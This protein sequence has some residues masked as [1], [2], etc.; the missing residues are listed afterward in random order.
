MKRKIKY[1]Q[2][3]LPPLA[4]LVRAQSLYL[5]GP[6]FESKR[7]DNI[8]SKSDNKETYVLLQK[9]NGV[10][11]MS[12]ESN[13]F[14]FLREGD[15][16]TDTEIAPFKSQENS[17]FDFENIVL[18]GVG[19]ELPLEGESIHDLAKKLVIKSLGIEGNNL[20][21]SLSE[22][23][24][25]LVYFYAKKLAEMN[26]I[27]DMDLPLDQDVLVEHFDV[28]GTITKEELVD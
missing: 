16:D 12:R 26:N 22:K 21:L 3:V 7:V 27:I 23:G 13:S 14:S 18:D 9:Q 15:D 19:Y 5:W 4:Q 28:T 6:W 24:E 10:T 1:Y 2:S 20:S 17:N 11:V 25:K 8:K